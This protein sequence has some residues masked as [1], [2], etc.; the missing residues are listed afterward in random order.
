M[1]FTG[2]ILVEMVGQGLLEGLIDGTG[3]LIKGTGELLG[4]ILSA[5]D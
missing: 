1:L 4:D 5:I 2:N 3:A